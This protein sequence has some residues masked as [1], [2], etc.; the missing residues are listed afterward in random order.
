MNILLLSYH[1]GEGT[2]ITEKGNSQ[3]GLRAG[4]EAML[5]TEYV[6]V[7]GTNIT[8]EVFEYFRFM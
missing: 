5:D 6:T 8:A 2:K 4:I 7:T 3:G 1:Q